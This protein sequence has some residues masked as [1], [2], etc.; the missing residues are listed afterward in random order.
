VAST[1]AVALSV[2]NIEL[3]PPLFPPLLCPSTHSLS[4]MSPGQ[5]FYKLFSKCWPQQGKYGI[6]SH[7]WLISAL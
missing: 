4:G 5:I 3:Y 7:A 1:L 2:T 6:G